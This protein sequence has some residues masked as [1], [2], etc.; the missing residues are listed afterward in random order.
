MAILPWQV[1]TTYRQVGWEKGGEIRM[2]LLRLEQQERGGMCM[3]GFRVVVVAGGDGA[4]GQQ[5]PG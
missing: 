3:R 4:P 1:G 5:L 2:M